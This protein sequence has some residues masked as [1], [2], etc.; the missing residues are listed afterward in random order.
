MMTPGAERTINR[1]RRLFAGSEAEHWADVVALTLLLEESLASA[2][3]ARFGITADWISRGALGNKTAVLAAREMM[4]SESSS[5]ATDDVAE[6]SVV[7]TDQVPMNGDS[8]PKA[9]V[10]VCTDDPFEFTLMMDR[11]RDIARRSLNDSVIS[12]GS[13]LLALLERADH[14]RDTFSGVGATLDVVRQ[15]LSPESD[16]SD[17]RILMDEPVRF[18]SET[19]ESV[20][21][22]AETPTASEDHQFTGTQSDDLRINAPRSPNRTEEDCGDQILHSTSVQTAAWR[23][24][25]ANLNR[26][27]EGLRVLEDAARFVLNVVSVSSSLKAVRHEMA[28]AESHLTEAIR[29]EEPGGLSFRSLSN[30]ANCDA[31]PWRS[32]LKR[33]QHRDTDGDVGTSISTDTEFIRHSAADLITANSRRVQESLRCLEE[34]GKL[35]S[36]NFAAAMKGLRYRS[37]TIEKQLLLTLTESSSAPGEELRQRLRQATVYVL[38]TEAQ[39]RLPW[40]RVVL[41]TLAGGADILQLREKWLPDRELLARACWIRDACQDSGALFIM[42]DRPDLAQLSQAHGVHVGQDE[43]SVDS[44]REILSYSSVVGVSTHNPVQARQAV[45]EGADYIG[46]GPVFRSVTKEFTEFPGLDFVRATADA[47]SVPWFAI[48]GVTMDRMDEL[49]L[50]GARRVAVTAA[51]IGSESPGDAVKQLK[52]KLHVARSDIQR[53]GAHDK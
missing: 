42:N 47:V 34:Y 46:V 22:G 24:I 23:V 52:S 13:L 40:K 31:S 1:C 9:G 50:A 27:R 33:L 21:S 32:H 38:V 51:V 28:K 2:L 19:S 14:I 26:A 18:A 7:V 6:Q 11:A 39:C 36:V 45:Q 4:A 49:I 35:V 3:L 41:E 43:L 5:S 16:T 25:D 48:G 17:L 37:Y 29:R 8:D 15:E 53:S 44:S 20:Q 10:W 30:D 12:S